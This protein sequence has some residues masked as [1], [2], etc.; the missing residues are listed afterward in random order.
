MLKNII[1]YLLLLKCLLTFSQGPA[2]YKIGEKE[3]RNTDVYTILLDEETDLVYAG[4]N[5]GLFVYRYNK[6]IKLSGPKEAIGSSFFDLKQD[7]NGDIFCSNFNGQIF[8]INKQKNNYN[9]Y[10]EIKNFTSKNNSIWYYFNKANNLVV[11]GDYFLKVIDK[12]KKIKFDGLSVLTTNT[13]IWSCKQIDKDIYLET[14]KNGN[15]FRKIY[16]LKDTSIYLKNQY[17]NTLERKFKAPKT[18]YLSRHKSNLFSINMEGNILC[19]SKL[20]PDYNKLEKER[21]FHINDSTFIAL[22]SQNGFRYFN[23]KNDTLSNTEIYLPKTFISAFYKTSKNKQLLGTF[24]EGIIVINNPQTILYEGDYLYTDIATSPTND[25]AI[26]ARS[27]EIFKFNKYNKIELIDKTLSNVDR[28]WYCGTNKTYKEQGFDNFIY[29]NS[30]KNFPFVKDLR[31]I[32]DSISLFSEWTGVSMII[33]EKQRVSSKL[34]FSSKIGNINNHLRII[35][36]TRCN[37][38]EFINKD[39]LIYF[40]NNQ[41]VY[42]KKWSKNLV[43][44]LS[45]NSLKFNANDLLAYNNLLF[46]GTNKNGVLVY[47]DTNLLFQI[48]NNNG[49]N[50]DYIIQLEAKDNVLYVLTDIGLQLYNLKTKKIIKI[51]EKFRFEGVIRFALSNDKLWLLTKHS[52]F[53]IELKELLNTPQYIKKPNLYLDKIKVNG[54]T[55]NR[56]KHQTFNYNQ[57]YVEFKYDYRD[58]FTKKETDIQFTLEGFYTEWKTVSTSNNSINF[59]SLPPGEYTFKIKAT[60]LGKTSKTLLYPFKIKPPFWQTWWFFLILIIFTIGIISYLFLLRIKK[61]KKENLEKLEKQKLITNSIDAELKAI[62]SQMNPHFIFNAI[63]SIQDLVLQKDTLQSYDSLVQFSTL[64]RN[65]L[66]Y[67]EQEQISINQ[68]IAFLT[69]Y[70]GLEKLRFKS[71]FSF[72]ILNKVQGNTQIPTLI[73]QPFVENAIKHGLLHKAGE[74]KLLIQFDKV[75]SQIVCTIKDNGIGRAKALEIKQRQKNFHKSFSTS[76]IKKRL[77]V[78]SKKTGEKYHYETINI[79]DSKSEVKGTEVKFYIPIIT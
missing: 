53:S 62:R 21:Y 75:A 70:L 31:I 4:T 66:E 44:H 10:Y 18:S 7:N 36:I 79:L 28:I 38:V 19:F 23:I 3:F 12:N 9:I 52:Y 67:S 29:N 46:C 78:L 56:N 14:Y 59:E 8:K 40:A 35:N 54:I 71:N 34:A 68:E 57:N 51:K 30:K 27:G 32:N 72:E 33:S 63:N 64:V 6:F 42:S 20:T 41:G 17:E 58:V 43:S 37:V 45:Y 22:N 61:I 69:T 24:G 73:I 65:T 47:K 48:D 15:K 13:E 5:R 1:L 60:C 55:I 2:Y 74:K 26:S 50:S 77:E 39:S 49:L 76:A 25:V 11:A 16:Q